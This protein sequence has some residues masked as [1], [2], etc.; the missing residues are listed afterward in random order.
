MR[1]TE[2]LRLLA[3]LDAGEQ[4]RL[5]GLLLEVVLDAVLGK[6]GIDA[7]VEPLEVAL[8]AAD[9]VAEAAQRR[10]HRSCPAARR[11]GGGD[12]PGPTRGYGVRQPL[13][14]RGYRRPSGAASTGRD[15][16]GYRCAPLLVGSVRG[17]RRATCARSSSALLDAYRRCTVA[18]RRADRKAHCSLRIC[19]SLLPAFSSR[20]FEGYAGGA[21]NMARARGTRPST[22]VASL[23]RRCGATLVSVVRDPI[24]VRGWRPEE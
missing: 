24:R 4:V 14:S 3:R 8:Q 20:C 10:D 21:W 22:Y 1:S 23:M 13:H 11:P 5:E 2:A 6:E 18:D 17:S 15:A 12:Q 7:V 9:A 19:A 16:D